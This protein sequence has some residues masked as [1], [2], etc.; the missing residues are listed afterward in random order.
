MQMTR[1]E[2]HETVAGRLITWEPSERTL[3]AIERAPVTGDR[4]SYMQET[5]IGLRLAME[6]DGKRDASWIGMAFDLP[7]E[8]DLE[9]MG[10]ALTAW[11]RRHAVMHG[12]FRVAGDGYERVQLDPADIEV[13]PR[14]VGTA[15][16]PG[17]THTYVGRLFDKVCT[18]LDRL[19]YGFAA[20]QGDAHA[21][22]YAGSDHTYSDGFSILVA[23]EE[24]NA[25]YREETTGT[26]AELP[27][28]ASYL[29]FAQAERAA[30]ESITREHPAVAYWTDYALKDL[31]GSPRFP[32]DL[33][34]EK[35]DKRPIRSERYDL[36]TAAETD[37][38]EVVAREAGATFPALVYAAC[39]AAARDLAGQSAYRFFNPVS[40][41]LTPE[42]AAAMGW[43]INV[44][45][46]HVDAP[47][48]ASLMDIARSTRQAF[49][50]GRA[51]QEVPAVRVLEILS[52]MF[53]FDANSTERPRIVS[54]LDGRKIPGQD[55]WLEQRFFGVTGGG[56][57]DDVNV[58]I[59]R[60]PAH[61]YV[62]CTVPD[63][64]QAVTNVERYFSYVRDVLRG[65]LA[66]TP[67]GPVD[68]PQALPV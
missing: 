7:G 15:A 34:L 39:A 48:D 68:V 29:E 50:D 51:S 12:W 65:E 66:G 21:V 24:V 23:F 28:V 42:T 62:T 49:R 67:A 57:D 33:G 47:A 22:M 2:K 13:V 58:W 40:T 20:V 31:E 25:L 18:P 3:A 55:A 64:P 6:R 44:M 11:V 9:A 56:D 35:G 60:M 17:G 41:R 26:P 53:G 1:L 46:V 52:E 37:A 27:E 10:R 4:P 16:S 8:L 61:T 38:L 45:P 63:F 30:A 36:L 32:M 43:F 5:H 19:G 14:V 54:Y 59:N